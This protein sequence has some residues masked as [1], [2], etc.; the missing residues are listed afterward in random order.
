MHIRCPHCRN[1]IEVV[2]ES[3]FRDMECPSCGS[4]FNLVGDVEETQSHKGPVKT[5]GHFTLIE[6]LSMGAFGTVYKAKDTKLDRFVAIKIPRKEQ[7]SDQEAEAFLRDARAAA[8][9]NHPN[10]VAVHEVGKDGDLLYIVSDYVDGADLREWMRGEPLPP[11][12]A[13]DLMIKIAEGI[14][15]AHKNGVIHR[16]LKPANIMM[17]LDRQPRVMD[18]GLAKRESGEI[19]MTMDGATLGTPAYM[20]PEQAR[21]KAHEADARSDVYS[22]G[23]ILYEMLT[24]S[25]PFRGEKRMLIVQI[26]EDEPSSIRRQNGAVAKDLETICLKC[27]QKKSESRYEDANELSKDLRRWLN[28]EP[29]HARPVNAFGRTL[30]WYRRNRTIASATTAI[31]IILLLSSIVS[32]SFWWDSD[33]QRQA[34]ESQRNEARQQKLEAE[35]QRN[36]AKKLLAQFEELAEVQLIINR[37]KFWLM[38]GVMDTAGLSPADKSRIKETRNQLYPNLET[39]DDWEELMRQV[40]DAGDRLSK[41]SREAKSETLVALVKQE[42]ESVQVSL[43]YAFRQVVLIVAWQTVYESLRKCFPLWPRMEKFSPSQYFQWL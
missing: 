11:R 26:L 25:R 34:A 20:S 37:Y 4:H 36:E 24:G 8:Q 42:S 43:V 17:G 18:F 5:I 32:T 28:E 23:V 33:R 10:V 1:A 2:E 30:K 40:G 15:H 12:E 14:H 19:T 27:L 41:L 3:S 9:L 22:L 31:V 13:A 6:R 39:E 21:G 35:L 7:L 29:I 16:D 38:Y